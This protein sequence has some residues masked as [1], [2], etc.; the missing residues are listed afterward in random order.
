MKSA[1]LKL[2]LLAIIL[3]GV[4]V[5]VSANEDDMMPVCTSKKDAMCASYR[6]VCLAWPGNECSY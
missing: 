2:A 4:S 5:S 3:S 6:S 1:V